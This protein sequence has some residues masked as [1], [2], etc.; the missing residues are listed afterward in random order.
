MMVFHKVENRQPT[1]LRNTGFGWT[2]TKD[3]HFGVTAI[4]TVTF[5]RGMLT[6]FGRGQAVI[7]Q[8]S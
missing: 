3:F 4:D 5:V 6:F 8:G 7:E 1:T 2:V